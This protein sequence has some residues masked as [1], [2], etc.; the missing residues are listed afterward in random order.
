[1]AL[2]INIRADNSSATE[3]ERLWDQVAA[4]EV[5]P[6]MR[7]LG[8]RPHFTF[9]IYDSPSI[10]EKI[11]WDAMLTAVSGEAQLRIEFRQIRWFEGSPLVLW[12][13]PASNGALTRIHSAISAAM[14][15]PMTIRMDLIWVGC[16]DL[17][18]GHCS[19]HNGS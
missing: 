9:A 14:T 13:D 2:A 18:A 19:L 4:F 5:E 11:A 7:T 8:Y 3:I 12:G 6:S 16:G 15:N 1:V 17:P 10:S